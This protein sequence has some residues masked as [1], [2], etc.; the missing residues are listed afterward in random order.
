MSL[1]TF[2]VWRI[3]YQRP[4]PVGRG[5]EKCAAACRWVSDALTV[6]EVGNM[7]RRV[8]HTFKFTFFSHAELYTEPL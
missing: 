2:A 6:N 5:F 1:F 7:F 3:L 4:Q 8:V